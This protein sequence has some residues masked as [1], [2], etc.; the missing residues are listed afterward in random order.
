[1]G[2]LLH[3]IQVESPDIARYLKALDQK[4]E[5]LGR[6]LLAAESNLVE[7][8]AHPVNLSASG[9]AFKSKDAV[10][11]GI[12]LELRLLLY[13][14]LAGI[15][16]YGTVVDCVALEEADNGFTHCIRVNFTHL[17]ESDRDLLI[18]HVVQRQTDQ[19]RKARE[20]RE[21]SQDV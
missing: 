16:A 10:K 17:R 11:P 6:T 14:S 12:T 21:A 2:G 7:Q 8:H 4:I 9:M 5:L 19:L 1:M 3:K 20:E 18:R 13:P 15:L